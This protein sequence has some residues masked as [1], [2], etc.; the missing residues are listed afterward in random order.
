MTLLEHDLGAAD[1]GGKGF[2][3][4]ADDEFDPDGRGEVQH[5]IDAPDGIIDE[6]LVE[7]RSH[8]EFE[9]VVTNVVADVVVAAGGEV[10]EDHDLVAPS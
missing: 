4:S 1:I 7:D 9:V 6:G 5:D 2:Q 10:I 8:D 3:R